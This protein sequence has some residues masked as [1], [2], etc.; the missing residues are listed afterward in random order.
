MFFIIRINIHLIYASQFLKQFKFD[1][2]Y[3]LKKQYIISN[4]LS[5][6][7]SLNYN[8][9]TFEY[10]KFDAL[11]TCSL[12]NIFDNFRRRIINNYKKNP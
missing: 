6:L 11:Y 4:A 5:R 8:K 10:F 7:A 3:K 12:I 9:K 1:I 2:K